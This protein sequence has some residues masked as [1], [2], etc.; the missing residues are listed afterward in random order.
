MDICCGY[1]R[2][3]FYMRRYGVQDAVFKEMGNA[4]AFAINHDVTEITQEDFTGLGG[5]ACAI[6]YINSA[7][8]AMTLNCLKKDNLAIAFQ[9]TV[10]NL[11]AEDSATEEHEVEELGALIPLGFIPKK[12]TVVVTDGATPTPETFVEGEDFIVTSAGIIPLVGGSITTND[13]LEVTYTYGIGSVVEGI[14]TGQ[15]V[16][17]ILFDGINYGEDGEQEVVLRVWRVKFGPTATFNLLTAGEFASL[18]VTGQILKDDTKVG[19][20]VSKYYNFESREIA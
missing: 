10:N 11:E 19:T 20:G 14:T 16:Y 18:E 4:S 9:G 12:G 13:T 8:L 15:Q 5:N 17:E 1:F 6:S 7:T 2:G 3:K